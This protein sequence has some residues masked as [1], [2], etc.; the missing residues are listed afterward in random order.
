MSDFE[1][2]EMCFDK[3]KM[4]EFL[5]KNNFKTARSYIKKE[6]FYKDLKNNEITFPVFVKPVRGS[7]SLNIN[8]INFVSIIINFR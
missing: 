4:Y 2:V 7:A 5:V 3:Y 6:E 1:K 8:R